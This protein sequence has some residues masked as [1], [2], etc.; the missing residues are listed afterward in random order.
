MNPIGRPTKYKPEYCQMLIEH[1]AQ[2]LSF[3][4]FAAKIDTTSVRLYDWVKRFPDFRYAKEVGTQKSLMF[5]EKLGVNNI[6]SESQ[7]P[8]GWSRSLNSAVYRLQM[9]NRFGWRDK[10][11]HSG[12]IDTS[13][14]K[15]KLIDLMKDPKLAKAAR[16]VALALGEVEDEDSKE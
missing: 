10:V 12:E 5:W 13:G 3:M 14:V 9:A 7:S 2:G 15:N 16:D 8:G 1:M 6:I 4:S 11:D